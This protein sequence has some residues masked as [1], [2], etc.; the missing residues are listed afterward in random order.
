M[1]NLLG[2]ERGQNRAAGGRREG[3]RHAY[4]RDD[5]VDRQHRLRAPQGD[6]EQHGRTATEADIAKGK[7]FAAVVAI[8]NVAGNEKEQNAG[9]ELREADEAKVQ[10]A[11]GDF[12]NLPAD[13]DRL[14]F[15]GQ[16]DAE[17]R[18]LIEPKGRIG[19]GDGA[20]APFRG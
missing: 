8:G 14:H 4:E 19:E 6:P 1:E 12:V 17:S 5:D 16:D 2:H 10:R 15:G 11:L 13:G 20:W 9:K 18:H 7:K 3:A